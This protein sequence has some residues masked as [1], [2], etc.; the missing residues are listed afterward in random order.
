MPNAAGIAE[1]RRENARLA[2]RLDAAGRAHEALQADYAALQKTVSAL[3]ETAAALK[4]QLDWFKRQLF[5][6]RSEKRLEIDLTEQAS[7]FE[8]LSGGDVPAPEVPA[9]TISYR[10]RRKACGDAVNESGLR[11]DDTW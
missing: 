10:R 11:F 1:L 2:D 7:L 5:G 4:D 6:R 3:R 9:E 8:A